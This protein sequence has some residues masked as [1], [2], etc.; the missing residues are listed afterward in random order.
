[1]QEGAASPQLIDVWPQI[2]SSLA[3]H[4]IILLLANGDMWHVTQT[5]ASRTPSRI[6]M[7][8]LGERISLS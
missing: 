5:R 4:D 6:H 2:G 3:N 1:M 8:E 7:F